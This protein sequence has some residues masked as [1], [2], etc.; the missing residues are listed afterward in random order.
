[1]ATLRTADLLAKVSRPLG[2]G[3]K[4]TFPPNNRL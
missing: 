3:F 2:S 1:M 4:T